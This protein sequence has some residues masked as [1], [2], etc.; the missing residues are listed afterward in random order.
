MEMHFLGGRGR[1]RQV[2]RTL[3]ITGWILVAITVLGSCFAPGPTSPV[4][5]RATIN[6][7]VELPCNHNTGHEEP[8]ANFRVYW[9]RNN[10]V[11]FTLNDGKREL[12]GINDTYKERANLLRNFSLSLSAV[13]VSDEGTYDCYV[14]KRE[15]VRQSYQSPLHLA[16]TLMVAAPF[17]QPD[18]LKERATKG[19]TVNLTC[20]SYGGYPKPIVV[21]YNV[22]G[23][24]TLQPS[25]V[26]TSFIQDPETQTYN[27]SSLLV[28]EITVPFNVVCSV[29]SAYF[30]EKNS[31][32]SQLEIL[33]P[34]TPYPNLTDIIPIVLGI[35]TSLM[36]TV[37][38]FIVVKNCSP[39]SKE[40][41]LKNSYSSPEEQRTDVHL[42]ENNLDTR[43]LL[44][45]Y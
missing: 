13:K 26:S 1:L 14:S 27:L 42:E 32:I 24:A 18:I 15:D 5:V 4:P 35:A 20:L 11:V 3:Q 34:Q 36:I 6:S 19:T 39:C 29:Q 37:A 9:Q 23:N 12:D 31:T 7:T 25:F 21:W 45:L 40:K 33:P 8:L 16:V 17:S 44:L 38:T 10:T 30:P 22:T 2:S 41:K 28:T 43:S